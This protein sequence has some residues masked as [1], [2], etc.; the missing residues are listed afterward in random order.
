MHV[1]ENLGLVNNNSILIEY[2]VAGN[3]SHPPIILLH[4]AMSG[5]HHWRR[6]G[7]INTLVE[8]DFFVVALNLRGFGASSKP[9]DHDSY[10]INLFVEDVLCVMDHL[11]IRS[12]YFWG[13]SLGSKILFQILASHPDR[14]IGAIA[15][16][17]AGKLNK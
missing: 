8:N 10:T 4:G 9:K 15:G 6:L 1:S 13:Y 3:P 2:E 16:G 12:A 7:Y 11:S 5:I 14:V 17:L